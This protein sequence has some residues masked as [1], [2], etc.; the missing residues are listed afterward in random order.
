MDACK[1]EATSSAAGTGS[2]SHPPQEA[3]LDDVAA[4][5]VRSLLQVHWL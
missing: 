2:C 3:E 1:P 4:T 5:Q